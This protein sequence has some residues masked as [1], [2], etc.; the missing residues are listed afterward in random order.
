[1]KSRLRMQFPFIETFL[2]NTKA[3]LLLLDNAESK[4]NLI[5]FHKFHKIV[6]SKKSLHFE[7]SKSWFKHQ[8]FYDQMRWFLGFYGQVT[9]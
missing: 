1:M 7:V 2:D 5:K 6:A 3:F 9:K 8:I 4:I